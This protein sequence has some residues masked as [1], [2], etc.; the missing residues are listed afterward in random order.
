MNT[1][2]TEQNEQGHKNLALVDNEQL[3]TV[4]RISLGQDAWRRLKK[5][6]LA[7]A[8]LVIVIAY[9]LICLLAP[10]LPFYS[11]SYQVPE[12][13]FL[14]PSL[15]KTGGELWL[16]R[17]T[18][19][20]SQLAA[21]EDRAISSEERSELDD[22]R[23]RVSEG[24][25]HVF[26]GKEISLHDRKYLLGTDYLGRDMLARI[27]YGGQISI[28]IG[29]LGAITSVIIG[30]IVGAISGYVGGKVD[31]IITRFI[32]IL[33][34]LP[35]MLLV[36]ILMALFGQNTIN[37]FIGLSMISWLTVARVV[38]GQIISLK[39]SIFVEASRSVGSSVMRIIFR[40]LVPN[41]LGVIIV[42]ASLRVPAFILLEAFLSFLGL[43]V[44]APLASWGSLLRDATDGLSLYPWRLF[45]PAIVMSVF[46]LSMNFLGDGLRDAFDPQSKNLL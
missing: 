28:S 33:Y 46:L 43:G 36:I 44:S 4:R 2:Q 29:L 13:N 24:E 17:E 41:T 14:P 20:T 25:T 40:H 15:T 5:N 23:R 31:Y 3:Q 1:I 11:F 19:Y 8:G 10:I 9:S 26:E 35:Y 34:C 16:E 32:D 42:F 21:V 45:W 22:I 6:R 7:L 12:H 39:N 37:L 30:I 18:N 27:V 38:R